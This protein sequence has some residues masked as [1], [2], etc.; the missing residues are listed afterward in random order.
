M[1]PGPPMPARPPVLRHRSTSL[2]SA[3]SPDADRDADGD[4]VG[5]EEGGGPDVSAP[6]HAVRA[7]QASTAQAATWTRREPGYGPAM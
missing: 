3:G 5:E 7:V 1:L 2:S 6:P 4:A